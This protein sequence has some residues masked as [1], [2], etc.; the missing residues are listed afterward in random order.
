[1]TNYF[2]KDHSL[3][4][5]EYGQMVIGQRETVKI[6]NKL[7]RHFKLPKVRVMFNRRRP[8]HGQYI[9]PQNVNKFMA[10]RC[11]CIINLHKMVFSIGTIIH[12]VGHHMDFIKN[13][14]QKGRRWHTNKLLPMIK[15]IARYCKKMG[16]WGWV[17]EK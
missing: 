2:S 12:E 1:M 13:G 10:S 5:T 16:Y 17:R 8:N 11:G 7:C 9:H 14:S 15:R 3:L 6:I 4:A